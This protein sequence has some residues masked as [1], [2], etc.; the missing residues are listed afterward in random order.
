VGDRRGGNLKGGH[1]ICPGHHGGGKA[2]RVIF[3][4][5]PLGHNVGA[6][7]DTELQDA[8]VLGALTALSTVTE[9]GATIEL[10]YP[11]PADPAW[12]TTFV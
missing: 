3:I 1:L 10:R 11:W 6:P 7:F 5:F 4:H 8:I 2:P 9:P 12:E